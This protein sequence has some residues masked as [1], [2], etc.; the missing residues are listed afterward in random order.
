M[1]TLIKP[2][3][4]PV[5]NT[6]FLKSS[7][8]KVSR[9][10]LSTASRIVRKKHHYPEGMAATKDVLIVFSIVSFCM[11]ATF[12]SISKN[13]STFKEEKETSKVHWSERV[14][15]RLHSQHLHDY[16]GYDQQVPPFT[17]P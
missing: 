17:P 11:G 8:A 1:N 6:A 4:T 12:H 9:S 3:I 2:L 16:G 15:K 13:M 5:Q 7:F 14:D 10:F